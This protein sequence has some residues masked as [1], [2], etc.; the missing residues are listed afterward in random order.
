MGNVHLRKLNWLVLLLFSLAGYFFMSHSLTIGIILGGLII[1]ANFSIFQHTIRCA[2]SPERPMKKTKKSIIIMKYY[3]RL[4][5]MGTILYLLVAR[6]WVD[7]IGLAIGL[8]TVVVSIVGFGIKR[9]W[10]IKTEEAA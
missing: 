3:L 1:I 9:A 5:A 10:G 2:F 8:S 7:P 4:L 6:G